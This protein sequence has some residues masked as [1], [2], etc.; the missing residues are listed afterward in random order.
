MPHEALRHLEKIGTSKTMKYFLFAFS[1]LLISCGQQAAQEDP[2]SSTNQGQG[3]GPG[4]SQ[5]AFEEKCAKS[6]G[7]S[8]KLNRSVC[9]HTPHKLILNKAELEEKFKE[10]DLLELPVGKVAEGSIIWAEV[11]GGFKVNFYLNENFYDSVQDSLMSPRRI[12]AGQVT[13]RILRA[14]YE[15]FMVIVGECF[16]RK[17][18]TTCDGIG[19]IQ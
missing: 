9:F 13:A 17:G 4:M 16:N 12:S 7:G 8:L 5:R 3:S 18:S 19:V 14:T 6:N 1:F 10:G 11:K 2:F 15:S